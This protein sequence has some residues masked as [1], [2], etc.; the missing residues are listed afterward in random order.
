M[1]VLRVNLKERSYDIVNESGAIA[2]CGVLT[3]PVLRGKR[4][5]VV[6]DSNVGPRYAD[7]VLESFRGEGLEPVLLTVPAGESSKCPAMLAQLSSDSGVE[8]PR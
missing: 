2:R 1:S 5:F 8:A 7:L 3:A 4:V 6:A